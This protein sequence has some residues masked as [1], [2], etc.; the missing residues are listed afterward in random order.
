MVA[1]LLSGV[2]LGAAES[3]GQARQPSWLERGL[4]IVSPY[5]SAGTDAYG[6]ASGSIASAKATKAGQVSHAFGPRV[7][8]VALA[9][10]H[11]ALLK[12]GQDMIE[13]IE[14]YKVSA[15][16]TIA[17]VGGTLAGY[18]V[19]GDLR[20]IPGAAANAAA[21]NVVTGGGAWAGATAGAAA[22]S[23]LGPV[24]TLVGGAIGAATGAVGTSWGYDAASE[25]LRRNG[26]HDV[27]SFVDSLVAEA[28]VDYVELA[29][30]ARREWAALRE[31]AAR[32]AETRR[33]YEEQARALGLGS[34]EAREVEL[35]DPARPAP[36]LRPPIATPPPDAAVPVIPL[37]CTI[38]VV[39]RNP[40]SGSQAWKSTF[41]VNGDTVTARGE[42][43]QPGSQGDN[44]RQGPMRWTDE[45][46][47]TR[48]DNVISGTA[49]STLHRSHQ[50][51]WSNGPDGARS[52]CAMDWWGSYTS[53]QEW[54]FQLGGTGRMRFSTRGTT[55]TQFSGDCGGRGTSTDAI[56]SSDE[57]KP[58]T[59]TW[60][61]R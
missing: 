41:V 13:G 31:Q 18:I 44:Y 48:R 33:L 32:D 6:G 30:Q 56:N 51:S 9:N 52:T 19:E 39:M 36:V 28:P 3:K 15:A 58:F 61:I 7:V 60:R 38:D 47:G 40:S 8:R 22:G 46:T 23:F 17:D 53:Q 14:R 21:K 12:L 26:Y 11:N 37:D 25:A 4:E 50:E 42:H 35:I 55:T 20:A 2:V 10:D 54:A 45:F 57:G 59:F 29:R 16:T 1:L 5:V 34:G 43:V 49:R 27:Q 24:G